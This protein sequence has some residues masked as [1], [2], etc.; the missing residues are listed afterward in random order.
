M[1]AMSR[2]F[3]NCSK[4][5]ILVVAISVVSFAMEIR[6]GFGFLTPASVTIENNDDGVK[7]ERK[8]KTQFMYQGDLEFLFTAQYAPIRYG[9]GL[10]YK[11]KQTRDGI[12]FTPATLPLWLNLTF[13]SIYDESIFDP[14]VVTRLGYVMPLDFDD[15]WWEMPTDFMVYIGAGC[16]FPYRIALEAGYDYTSILKS[17]EWKKQKFRISSGRIAIRLSVGFEFSHRRNERRTII[18]N[19]DDEDDEYEVGPANSGDGSSFEESLQ[20][21]ED[22]LTVVNAQKNAKIASEEPSALEKQSENGKSV[23]M[24]SEISES[25]GKKRK[26]KVKNTKPKKTSSKKSA[27]NKK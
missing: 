13:G 25:T 4:I 15:P 7:S 22:S 12:D 23:E 27:K 16:V 20:V 10:G 19:A 14:Y 5:A 2:I 1:K 11:S 17:F 6:P 18:R 3:A 8:Q 9:L 24:S 21:F 26:A